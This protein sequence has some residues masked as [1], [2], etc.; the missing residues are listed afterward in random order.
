MT[1]ATHT[2]QALIGKAGSYAH[3]FG[4][5][6]KFQALIPPGGE[7]PAHLLLSLDMG[8]PRLS[9]LKMNVGPTLRLV[10]PFHYSQGRTFAYHIGADGVIFTPADFDS[11]GSLDWPTDNY[12]KQF[13]SR[14]VDLESVSI[15]PDR[16]NTDQIFISHTQP[17]PQDD[18]VGRCQSCK[19]PTHLFAVVPSTP[20]PDLELWGPSGK[21]V[22]AVFLYCSSCMAINTHNSSD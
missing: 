14:P 13:P 8:D 12:P 10:H 21:G 17:T 18:T 2:Y 20:L 19:A 11:I 22:M 6:P 16:F 5:D 3:T 9:F 7:L 15:D 4:H 1:P